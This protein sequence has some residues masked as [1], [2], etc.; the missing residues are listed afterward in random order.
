[1]LTLLYHYLKLHDY[2]RF[3]LNTQPLGAVKTIIK[4]SSQI[5]SSLPLTSHYNYPKAV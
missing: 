1:M 2:S 5:G 3:A 4:I